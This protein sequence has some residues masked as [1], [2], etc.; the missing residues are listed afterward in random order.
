MNP[1]IFFERSASLL[2]IATGYDVSV[3][4]RAIAYLEL[5][6]LHEKDSYKSAV[7]LREG[8]DLV[9]LI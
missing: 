3:K 6:Q 1:E 2:S 7:Y 4:E 8:L 9:R 5:A